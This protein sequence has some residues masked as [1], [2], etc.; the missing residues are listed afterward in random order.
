MKHLHKSLNDSQV[1]EILEKYE[2]D[3]VNRKILEELLGIEKAQ[4]FRLLKRYRKNKESVSIGYNRISNTSA[5]GK[6]KEDLILS[7]YKNNTNL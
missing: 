4:F 1:K 5:I 6:D 3:E 7:D 2:K